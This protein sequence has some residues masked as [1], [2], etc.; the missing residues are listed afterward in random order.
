MHEGISLTLATRTRR[1]GDRLVGV[2]S[3]EDPDATVM[4]MVTTFES[5]IFDGE[6]SRTNEHNN[7]NERTNVQNTRCRGS[8]YALTLL[9]H[10][11]HLLAHDLHNNKDRWVD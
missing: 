6:P 1:P 5:S 7:V 10:G 4:G 9:L 2:T 11:L 3:P 8:R